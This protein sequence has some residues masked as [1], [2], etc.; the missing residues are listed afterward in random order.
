MGDG[1]LKA[2]NVIHPSDQVA[3]FARIDVDGRA[4]GSAMEY[5]IG[6]MFEGV[7]PNPDPGH[8]D[9]EDGHACAQAPG[10]TLRFQQQSTAEN[11][12]YRQ[13]I[14]NDRGDIAFE[15][16]EGE[17]SLDLHGLNDTTAEA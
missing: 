13:P 8:Y 2:S 7:I 5:D 4:S 6:L 9:T 10:Y 12:G 14:R 15:I 16:G 3:G 1:L 17:K 11:E